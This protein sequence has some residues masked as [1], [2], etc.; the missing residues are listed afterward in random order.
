MVFAPESRLIALMYLIYNAVYISFRFVYW[1]T[2]YS[3]ICISYYSEKTREEARIREGKLCHAYACGTVIFIF[4]CTL[5]NL[6]YVRRVWGGF[7]A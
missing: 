7:C 6:S 2:K 4:D 5:G 1:F 3:D